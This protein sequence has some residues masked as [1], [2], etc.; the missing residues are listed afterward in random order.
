M[1]P[2]YCIVAGMTML[3]LLSSMAFAIP[4][5]VVDFRVSSGTESWAGAAG[6]H[7]YSVGDVTA[8]AYLESSQPPVDM[9]LTQNA[10]TGLGVDSSSYLYGTGDIDYLELLKV[11][12]VGGLP[13][14]GAWLTNLSV[15]EN[16]WVEFL[17]QD[18]VTQ[19]GTAL[20]TGNSTNGERFVGFGGIEQPIYQVR[21][22]ADFPDNGLNLYAYSVAGFEDGT[23]PM[24]AVPAPGAVLLASMGMGL[25]GWLKRR[26]TL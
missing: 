7:T 16:G 4:T 2:K 26:N 6:Q 8:T 10:T 3:C 21:F 1:N 24:N 14:A 11:D 9:F 15:G 23:P 18:G 13:L 17:G 25:V 5:L 20:F 12:I 22:Y 19:L